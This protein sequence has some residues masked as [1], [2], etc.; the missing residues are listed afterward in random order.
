MR[1]IWIFTFIF[2]VLPRYTIETKMKEKELINYVDLIYVVATVCKLP[3][4]V[5]F[6]IYI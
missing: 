5:S 4:A 3:F 1:Y 6:G 2:C